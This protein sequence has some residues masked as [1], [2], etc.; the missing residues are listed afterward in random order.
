M[1]R[2]EINEI[3]REA[4]EFF[5]RHHFYLPAWS[6]WDEEEWKEHLEEAR[7]VL[8]CALGWDITDFGSG[9]F[10][11]RGL[12]LF[13]LRNGKSGSYQKPYAEKIMMVRENQETPF[14]FHWSKMEDIINR[15]GGQMVFEL[16]RADDREDLSELPVELSI[17][18]VKSQVEPGAP[19]YLNPGQSLTLP[20]YLYHR[21][22]ARPGGGPVLCG[23]VS[24]V[25]DDSSDNRF[26]ES[27]GRFPDIE[28]D[29]APFRLM[30]PDYGRFR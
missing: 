5:H 12:V 11:R 3:I 10:H 19:L 30:V 7:E 17:D 18:G 1:K 23:E 27:V 24:M 14:H 29:E 8:D 15:G 21:F 20:Q 2:S 13:T 28:E 9:D 6:L 26:H 4:E 16:H 25:N 22:Y